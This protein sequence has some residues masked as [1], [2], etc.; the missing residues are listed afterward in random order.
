MAFD[1]QHSIDAVDWTELAALYRAAPLGNKPPDFLR[2]VFGNS[3]HTCLVYDGGRLVGA[4][5]ALA[6][7]ADCACLCDIAVHPDYQGS[8]LGRV[9]V[10]RLLAATA[11]HRKVLLYS[12][13]GRESFYRRFGFRRLLSAMA[14]FQDADSYVARGYLDGD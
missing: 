8:G 4:G 12:V 14:R 9:L 2:T 11:G 10:E 13:P 7:G 5:R 1:W 6:D 3:R